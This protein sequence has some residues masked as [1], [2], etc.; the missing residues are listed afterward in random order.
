MEK[1]SGWRN[2]KYKLLSDLLF[3]IKI[4]LI[5]VVPIKGQCIEKAF[6][7]IIRVQEIPNFITTM[8]N[9]S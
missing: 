5:F 8:D 3:R 9:T 6:K 1:L 4:I 2:K 7:G